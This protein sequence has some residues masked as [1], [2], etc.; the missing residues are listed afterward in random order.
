MKTAEERFLKAM[1]RDT[2]MV[3]FVAFLLG[4]GVSLLVQAVMS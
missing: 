3:G 2:A 1:Q 4:A